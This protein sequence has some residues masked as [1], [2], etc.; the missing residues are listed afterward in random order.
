MEK[1]ALHKANFI[2]SQD[3]NTCG[4]TEEYEELEIEFDA[5]ATITGPD[6]CFIVIRTTTG[7]SMD[8]L[9]ELQDLIERC[10]K[11]L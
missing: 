3:G 7:W 4:T 5:P 1:P 10:K 9:D 11:A 2:F 6:D 8:S